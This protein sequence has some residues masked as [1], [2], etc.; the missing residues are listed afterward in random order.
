[1]TGTKQGSG[2]REGFTSVRHT[3]AEN[4]PEI[5][6]K[7]ENEEGL[8]RLTRFGEHNEQCGRVFRKAWEI[9]LG[10][11]VPGLLLKNCLCQGW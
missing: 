10:P 2:G 1:M 9:L 4:P 11:V 5:Q 8:G 6:S 3:T 7:C